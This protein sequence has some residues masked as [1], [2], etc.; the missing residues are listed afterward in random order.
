MIRGITFSEQVFYSKDFA[1]FQNVFLDGAC[2]TTKGC[3]ITDMQ[4]N[5]L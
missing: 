1:H 3:E 5:V 4:Q 2:G